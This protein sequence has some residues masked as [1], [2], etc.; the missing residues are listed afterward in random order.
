MPKDS[1]SKTLFAPFAHLRLHSEF[2][3]IDG[4][5]TIKPL[6]QRLHKMQMPAVAITD[7]SNMFA[8]IKFYS[9]ASKAGLKPICGCDIRVVDEDHDVVTPLVLLIKDQVGYHNLTAIISELYTD[10]PG[11]GAIVVSRTKLAEKSA[12]LIALSGAQYGDIGVALLAGEIKLAEQRLAQWQAMFPECFYLELQRLDKPDEDAYID[13]A[14][15]LA[16][17]WNC[18]VVASNDVRFLDRE[19]F[20]AHEVRVCINEG[21]ALD[22]PRR[23]RNYT[24]QQY[25]KSTAEMAKLFVDIPE[26]IQNAGEIALRCSLTLKLGA[27]SLPS[28]PVPEGMGL[29]AYLSSLSK[30]GLG[31]RLQGLFEVEADREEALKAYWDRLEIELKI[32]NQMGFCGYFLIVMEFI[33]WAKD[34]GIPVGPG[35]GSGAGSI[36]AYALGITDIDPLKYD[37]LFERFLNPERVSMPDFDVDFCMEGRD[38]VIQHVAQLYGKDAVAQIITFGT[39]AAKAVVRDVARAQGKPYS[40]GDKLSKLIPFE[41]GMTLKKAFEMEPQLVEFVGIDDDAQEIMEMAYK[42]EGITRNV[43]K[44]AGG[45]VIAPTK[46]TDFTPLY[47][48]A[49]GHGLM[50]QFDKNDVETVGLVKFDF[51]GLRTL[52]IIDWAVK[53]INAQADDGQ[54]TVDINTLPLD[55]EAVYRLLQKGETTAVFQL[56]SRGMKD[57]IKRLVPNSFD[58][59]IALVALFRPGPLQSG[60][61]EDFIDRKH[62]R[63]RVVYSHPELEPV[64]ATTYGVILYQEQVMQIAQVLADYTLGGADILRKAMGKKDPA[65]MAKQRSTFMAGA[66]ARDVDA[67]VATSIF[68][69]MEKFAGY[70]FNKSHSA[71][72]ALVSYQ[73]AWLKTH[74]PA[75]FMAAVLSAEMQN[76]DKIVTLIDE[77]R[78]MQL[79]IIPPDINAGQFNFTV[80]PGG[81]IVYGLGAIKG[82][83]EGPVESLL[84]AREQKPFSDLLDFCQRVDSRHA[85]KR[86]M[87]A[88]LRA[89]ALD[90]LVEGDLD[91]ARAQLTVMLPR[92]MQ[93]AEQA[94]RNQASGMDDLFGSI[95]PVLD[96]RA[97]YIFGKQ[98]VKP[99]AEQKRLAAEK[100]ALGVYLSGHPIDEFLEELSQLT[101]DRIANLRPQ[102]G[103]QLVAGLLYN[104]RTMRSKAGDTI[105]FLTLDDRSGR[106]EV[107]LYAKEYEKFRDLLSKDAILVVECIVSVDDYTGGSRGRARQVMTLDQA[108][109]RCAHRLALR[110]KFNSLESDFCQH[111]AKILAPYRRRQDRE[112]PVASERA[113]NGADLLDASA[114]EQANFDGASNGASAD[115]A[116]GGSGCTVVVHYERADSTGCIMLG[117][118]WVVSPADDLIQKLRLEYGRDK[119]NLNYRSDKT[120]LSREGERS[121]FDKGHRH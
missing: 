56:E 8:L 65:E 73:T 64:L 1:S 30:Q 35:R 36:V 29:E 113:T 37:L 44:H 67:K 71:A 114:S 38:R 26:A 9:G 108:R 89:G 2:S 81:E 15:A 78:S 19:D 45:V 80:N 25:L 101:S 43:G 110:L 12:G 63:T 111:L 41:P 86:T 90:K 61:V 82:V 4:L 83:G 22:D 116:E 5:I 42:L 57:L 92:A 39:M 84:L 18:P 104:V 31:D 59:I 23:S 69:L 102:R 11:H 97:D 6:L 68:D 85:N 20:D 115:G 107:S 98:Q 7:L 34:N 10:N 75:Y 50:T 53:M 76:T 99:W 72:Y 54:A 91:S 52:T 93:A 32:I 77:C 112:E 58:D 3:I 60:M 40:L 17:A 121:G 96:A 51:L 109:E 33:Q 87:E 27:P 119:V 13:A 16:R 105:A 48:D 66:R 55:D 62:G 46:L 120:L 70:G 74:H 117:Q 94:N 24:E 49:A 88:L 14:L 47:C 103:S 118:D 21:R 79:A 95:A 100:E 106:L 28:Y